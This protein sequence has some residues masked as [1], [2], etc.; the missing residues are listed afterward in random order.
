MYVPFAEAM[1]HALE[2]LS[3]IKVDGLTEFKTHVAFVPL[4]HMRK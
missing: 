1:N 4:S 2:L 3:D